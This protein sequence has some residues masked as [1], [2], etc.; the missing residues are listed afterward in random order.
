MSVKITALG[1]PPGLAKKLE[2]CKD[3]D[4]LRIL[5]P[6]NLRVTFAITEKQWAKLNERLRAHGQPSLGDWPTPPERHA[7]GESLHRKCKVEIVDSDEAAVPPPENYCRRPSMPQ[8]QKCE[9]H[10]LLGQPIADQLAFARARRAKAEAAES[11]EHRA[12]VKPELW[13][14][15]E[16]WCADCQGFVPLFYCRGSRCYA[17]ASEAAH[18][19]MV[20]RV[21]EFSK[22]D[23]DALLAWQRGRCYICRQLP[24]SKR[25]AVDHDHRSGA[26]RGLLCA[27]DEFGCNHTLRVLLNNVE[28][29]QRAL[30]Y[31]QRTPLQR[32]LA[33]EASPFAQPR[34][35][36]MLA[37]RDPFAGFLA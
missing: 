28:M 1:L 13:P 6:P 2:Q 36:P 17:H 22:E 31:V 35:T 9:W 25:L 34:P 11:F 15:G 10:W 37:G 18:A 3:T 5:T 24:R 7:R 16:R 27:S 26:V 32:M 33:G 23:Y 29:A 20:K 30:E 8:K 12:R 14:E 21:Y 19:S 4:G